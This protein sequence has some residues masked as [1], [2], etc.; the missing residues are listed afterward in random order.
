M[1]IGL[2]F[3]NRFNPS[4]NLQPNCTQARARKPVEKPSEDLQ[5]A[6]VPLKHP[7]ISLKLVAHSQYLQRS[8]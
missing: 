4:E 6:V 7:Q 1:Q 8:P 2:R 3:S 5:D